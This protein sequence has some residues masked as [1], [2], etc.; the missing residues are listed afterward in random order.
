MHPVSFPEQNDTLGGGGEVDD[1]P[2]FRDG[3]QIISCWALTPEE[4]GEIIATG[5]IYLCVLSP[6]THPPI[7]ITGEYPFEKVPH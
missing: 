3:T 7:K 4:L 1:L 5:R 6:S 2:I